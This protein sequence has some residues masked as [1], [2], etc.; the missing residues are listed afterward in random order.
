ML[1]IVFSYGWEPVPI[2]RIRMNTRNMI[3]LPNIK[4]VGWNVS[5][6]TNKIK[7]YTTLGKSEIKNPVSLP[8][9][10]GYKT[11]GTSEIYGPM[12]PPSLLAQT[13]AS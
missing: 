10:T 12:A 5:E 2:H 3:I 7:Q 6:Q 8:S 9:L 1:D 11:L 4:T 13:N